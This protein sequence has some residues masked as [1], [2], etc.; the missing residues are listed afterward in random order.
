MKI[1]ENPFRFWTKN[2]TLLAVAVAGTGVFFG[3]QLTLFNNFIV[4]RL[5]HSQHKRVVLVAP[6]APKIAWRQLARRFQRQLVYL[7]LQRFSAS[8]VDRLRRFHVLNRK[9]FRSYASHF[10]R[11]FR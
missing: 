10:I 2:F 8:T 9:E 6:E 11:D 4:E 5:K 3:V 1:I 7:P